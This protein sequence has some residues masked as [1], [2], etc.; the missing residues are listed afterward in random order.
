MNQGYSMLTHGFDMEL[1]MCGGDPGLDLYIMRGIPGCGKSHRA[2]K[3]SQRLNGAPIM[4]ADNFFGEGEE[5]KKNWSISKAH[6]G[7]RDCEAKVLTAMKSKTPSIIVDNTNLV[8][9]MFRVYL[10]Y[11]LDHGYAAHLVYPDSPW[12]TDTVHPFLLVKKQDDE[13]KT[14]AA[15][16]AKLLFQKNVHGVPES[17]LTDMLMKFQWINYDEYA[18]ATHQRVQALERELEE[19]KG[20]AKKLDKNYL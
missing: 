2:S 17:T 12:W 1:F 7:H 6:L 9:S 20:R 4:S 11:A 18:E 15:E 16:I 19:M 3:L 14:Q 13:S 5:Y 8:L 10:D